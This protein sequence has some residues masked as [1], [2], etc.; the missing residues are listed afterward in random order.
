[1]NETPN[2]FNLFLEG[3][4]GPI[5]LLLDLAKKQKVNLSNISILELANQYELEAALKYQLQRL[6]A[7]QKISKILYSR[8]LIGRDVFYRG[9]MGG[10]KIKYK[11]TYI[12]TLFDLLKSYSLNISKNLISSLTI[13]S[14]DLFSVEEA[15][16]RLRNII[17]SFQEWTNFIY[18]IPKL[19]GDLIINKSA[20]SSN[21]VASLE[22]V[23]NGYIEVKQEETFGNIFVRSKS[24]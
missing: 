14:S 5:D 10:I 6:E 4:E 22:L 17:G 1:M 15:I 2:Q 3:Y 9:F 11:I 13:E 23:K 21:F 19:K 16:Q 18:L 8:P 12:A 24:I 7:M 20:I